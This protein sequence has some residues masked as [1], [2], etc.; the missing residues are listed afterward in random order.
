M[1]LL[2]S[3]TLGS[4]QNIYATLEHVDWLV[5]VSRCIYLACIPVT[6]PSANFGH[7]PVQT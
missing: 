4:L 3:V 6:I 5:E 1:A 2:P 7:S